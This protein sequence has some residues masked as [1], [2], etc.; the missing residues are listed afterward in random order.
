M[1]W[2]ARH[3]GATLCIEGG[4]GVALSKELGVAMFSE[5]EKGLL[6]SVCEQHG[7]TALWEERGDTG[8]V[9]LGAVYQ[10]G[11]KPEGVAMVAESLAGAVVRV[12]PDRFAGR[13]V[14]VRVVMAGTGS[15]G[16]GANLI[17]GVLA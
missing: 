8:S 3:A 13:H 2:N 6:A 7:V 10:G 14:D 17:V 4:A 9:R 15:A 11:L 1:G 5:V 16:P 12:A